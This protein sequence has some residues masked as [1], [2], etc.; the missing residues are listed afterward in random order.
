MGD[1]SKNFSRWEF[2]CKC[3]QYCRGSQDTVDYELVKVLE[4]V[5]SHFRMIYYDRREDISIRITSGNRCTEHNADIG[6]SETSYHVKC[7][8][9][10][11]VVT[12]V[13]ADEVADYLEEKYPDKYGIGR[14]DGRTHLDVRSDIGRWDNRGKS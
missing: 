4:D 9:S 3:Q 12:T 7:K 6:G 2:K 13:H 14:Y 8:A 10:D 1:L 11:F 5:R